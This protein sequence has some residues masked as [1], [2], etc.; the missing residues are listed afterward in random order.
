[1]ASV[2]SIGVA[3]RRFEYEIRAVRPKFGAQRA[4]SGVSP[5]ESALDIRSSS[6]R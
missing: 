5:R 2:L 3:R 1:M 6:A 4:D